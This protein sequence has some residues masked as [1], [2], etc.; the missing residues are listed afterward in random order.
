MIPEHRLAALLDEVKDSWIGN[1]LYHNTADS[2]SLYLD[3]NCERDDFPTKVVLDLKDHK[4]EV[5]YLKFSNDGTKLA[6]TSKDTTIIIYET[7]TYNILYRFEDHQKSGVTHLAWSP[8]DT[9][10]ITCCSQPENSARIWDVRTGVCILC[11]DDFTYPCTTAAWAPDGQHVVIGSQDDKLGCGICDL[12]GHQVHNFCEDG[13]KLRANDLAISPNGE[14]LIVVSEHSIG[15]YDF[16]SHKKLCEW[17][18]DS[19]L[20]SVAISQDSRHMLVSMNPDMIELMEID[21]ADLVQKFEGHQQ[22][23]FIIRSAFGGAD[24]NFVVSGSEGRFTF[25]ILCNI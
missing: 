25:F 15:V 9:K 5:W 23:Q 10:I 11:I 13:S 20:T 24:E 18:S 1:C 6:S 7:S 17:H 12:S 21:S 19:K 14:R 4:D 8:D 2:P 3:H 16:I 22:K